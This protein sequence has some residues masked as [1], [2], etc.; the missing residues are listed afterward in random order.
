MGGG[1]GCKGEGKKTRAPT[2]SQTQQGVNLKGCSVSPL[3]EGCAGVGCSAGRANLRGAVVALVST[4]S[5]ALPS[6]P[7]QLERDRGRE[8]EKER[9]GVGAWKSS[10]A[11][12]E[13]SVGAVWEEQSTQWFSFSPSLSALYCPQTSLFSL[14]QIKEH[15]RGDTDTHMH[16][17]TGVSNWIIFI[18]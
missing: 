1:R 3:E 11:V 5:P 13:R 14:P 6:Y 15:W 12:R 8:G 18:Q 10:A 17:H 7:W 2:S 16:V 9:V 4:G